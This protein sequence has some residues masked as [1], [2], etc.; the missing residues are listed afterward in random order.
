MNFTPEWE[1]R[2]RIWM[3]EL[4]EYF[5]RPLGEI[6]LEGFA[7]AA[8]LTPEEAEARVFSL[9]PVGTAWG[10][11]W[12]YGWFRGRV[13][14]PPSAAGRRV[15]L[16]LD[17]GGEA[18]VWLNGQAAGARDRE[19]TEILLAESAKGGETFRILAESYAGHGP[20]LENGVPCPPGTVTVPVPEGPQVEVGRSTFGIWNED[21]YQLWMD[22]RTLWQLR[23]KLDRNSLRWQ[24]VDRALRDAALAADFEQETEEGRNASFRR[25]RECLAEALGC[26]NGSTAPVMHM[27]GQSHL[28][29]AWLWPWQETRRKSARTVSNQLALLEEYPAY[30]FLWCEPPLYLALKEHYPELYGRMREKMAQGRIFA[31][32]AVWVECDTNLPGG[33]SLIRQIMYGRRFYRDE[34]DTDSRTVW[35]PDCFG[36]SAALPQIMRG[37]GVR[38]FA[39]QKII[40]NYNGGEPFPYNIFQWEGID[41]TRILTHIFKKNN[42]LLDPGTVI[43]RWDEDRS[44]KE[45]IDTFLYPFGYGDG[46]GG[47][48]RDHVE[49]M[50]RMEDLEGMPRMRVSSLGEFFAHIEAQGTKNRYVGE[51]YF[52]CHRGT[53]TSQAAIKKGNRACEFALRE[54]DFWGAWAGLETGGQMERLWKKLL[55]NQFHDILPGASIHRVCQEARADHGEILR[56]SALLARQAQEKLA[57]GDHMTLWNSLS[58]PRTVLAALPDGCC[59]AADENGN[60]L[61]CQITGGGAVAEVELPPC[62]C[63]SIQPLP[64]TGTGPAEEAEDT[65][66]VLENEY[67]RIRLDREGRLA[68]VLDLETGGELLSGPGNEFR[69]YRDTPVR[70]EA[71]DIDH[72]YPEMPA[73]CGGETAISW[74]ENGPLFQTI[75]VEKRFSRSVLSQDITLRRGQRRV[76][77]AVTV[78]WHEHHKLLKVAFPTAIQTT[79]ALHEIQFGYLKRPT[80]RSRQYDK[81]RFEVVNHKYTALCEEGRGAAVL[82]DCKYGV[83]AEEGAIALTLLRAPKIP[84]MEADMGEH[85]FTYAF[86][87]WNGSFLACDVVR[88]AYELNVPVPVTPGSGSRS[89]LELSNPDIILDTV[90]RAEDGSGDLVLRLYESK[91]TTAACDILLR[92]GYGQ[93][94]ETNLIE[95]PVAPLPV[96]Q[97]RIRLRFRPFEIKTIRLKKGPA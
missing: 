60:P 49:F 7:T 50:R 71:W 69:L 73:A 81:D 28:D 85:C 37:C 56:E 47:P 84:D 23:E 6:P 90:K 89:F 52:Q 83:S 18:L 86:T 2:M 22:W 55:F 39:T 63:R 91:R 74:K 75:R 70:Y 33:E 88:E 41:G 64:G 43:T 54:A 66:F 80:H 16:R 61:P 82:N 5:Y 21:A 58:W 65:P 87:F 14:L 68:S 12:E 13:T 15:V 38:Y 24:K 36:F 40:R 9:Y 8:Q 76:E 42:A 96:E 95:E 44:Q 59:G 51:L 4:P 25:A 46:G 1:Q 26:H 77:F 17:M 20:R 19:H 57:A 10:S 3:D 72:I 62:G 35:L 67:V 48:V 92:D 30:R 27:F 79:D 31:D 32:G 45:D 53:Y 94:E 29:L 93:A 11:M 97:N 78:D 34:L